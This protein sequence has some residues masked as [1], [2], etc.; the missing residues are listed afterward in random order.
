MSETTHDGNNEIVGRGNQNGADLFRE[1]FQEMSDVAHQDRGAAY[2]FVMGSV[3]EILTT[4]IKSF[5][6]S[7][8]RC[9]YS[10]GK[11]HEL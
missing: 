7:Y 6:C 11:P 4:H 1:W 5:V 3:N 10:I 8:I 2:V 9:T